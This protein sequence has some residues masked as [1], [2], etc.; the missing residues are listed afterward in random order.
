MHRQMFF[1]MMLRGPSIDTSKP[2]IDRRVGD[3][4]EEHVRL[5]VEDAKALLDRSTPDRL[6]EVTLAGARCSEEERVFVAVDELAGGEV[7]D[8][9]A[10]HLLVEAPVEGIE[11]AIA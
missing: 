10:V 9:R 11:R 8:E 4:F 7:E 5:A 2:A 1:F 3:L 6:C